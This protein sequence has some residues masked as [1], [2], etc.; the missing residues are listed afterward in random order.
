MIDTMNVHE[1][2]PREPDG[3]QLTD[4]VALLLPGAKIVKTFNQLPAALLVR[5]PTQGG[6]R[7]VMFVAG[8]YEGTNITIAALLESLGFAPIILGKIAEGGSLLRY[9]G[10]MVL[11]NIIQQNILVSY[12]GLHI[13]AN[14]R[15]QNYL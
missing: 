7:R 14:L 6:G 9:R 1:A 2:S 3:L 13:Q 4:A 5:E 12:Y 11:Q 10:S 8:N 15:E